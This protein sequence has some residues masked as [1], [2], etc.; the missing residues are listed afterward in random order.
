MHIIY[1][2]ESLSL[3][4]SIALHRTATENEQAESE[5]YAKEG[6]KEAFC[7][8]TYIGVIAFH[9]LKRSGDSLSIALA[10]FYHMS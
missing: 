9:V 6:K 2:S 10:C 1:T 8:F 7:I 4:L 5:Q 3:S